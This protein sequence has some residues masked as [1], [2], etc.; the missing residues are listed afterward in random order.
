M[1]A[2]GV[3]IP[4]VPVGDELDAVRIRNRHEED[5]IVQKTHRFLV[6]LR[7]HLVNHLGQRLRIDRLGGMETAIDPDDRLAFLR[8][9]PRLVLTEAGP[10]Q[11]RGHVAVGLELGVILRRRD[12][13]HVLRAPFLG[14]ADADDGHAVRF[15]VPLLQQRRDLGVIGDHVI[16]ADAEADLI[17]GLSDPGLS[18][19]E[20]GGRR[21]RKNP[22]RQPLEGI[23]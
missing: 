17:L 23:L 19:R 6:R 9:L 10:G 14:R 13:R 11:L 20:Q 4:H 7:N 12:D 21:E 15:R 2:L 18:G 16:V 3:C 1:R 22:Q 8:E 5:D